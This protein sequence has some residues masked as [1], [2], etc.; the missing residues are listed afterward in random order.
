MN[1]FMWSRDSIFLGRWKIRGLM[2]GLKGE[3]LLC[4]I[5][6]GLS[7]IIYLV[8]LLWDYTLHTISFSWNLLL[9]FNDVREDVV[10]L[11]HWCYSQAI[12]G[13]S[14]YQSL[15]SRTLVKRQDGLGAKRFSLFTLSFRILK[16]CIPTP[17]GFPVYCHGLQPVV[18]VFLSSRAI[19]FC[20]RSSGCL[21]RKA[22]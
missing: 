19:G 12:V 1:H 14:H 10:V 21:A 4:A 16:F 5:L 2:A 11:C 3:L 17:A 20:H 15:L 7:G 22:V 6:P 8:T 13:I 18:N 9:L